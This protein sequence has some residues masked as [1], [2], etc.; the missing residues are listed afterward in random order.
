[1]K[2][3]YFLKL[4][5]FFLIL[6]TLNSCYYKPF[7]GYITNKKDFKHFS[8]NEKIAG[9]HSNIYRNYRV[10]K[11]DWNVEVFPEKKRIAGEM[12]IYFT[13]DSGQKTFLF[14]MQN[15]LKIK[16]SD[17]SIDK[18]KIKRN[19][20]LLYLY[21]D[22]KVQ[23]NTR[24]KLTIYYEGKPANLA[25]L[26]PIIW[27]KDKKDR[28]WIS[29]ATE[30]IGP[31]F[32]MPCNALLNAEADS[33]N[34]NVTV[35]KDLTAVANGQLNKVVNNDTSNTK[36]YYYKVT[37]PINNYNISFNVGHFKK[38]SKPYVDINGIKREIVCQVLDYNYDIADS[39]YNQT[40]KIMHEFEL[41]YGEFPWWNDGCKFVESN[42]AAM[43]HQSGI[44]LGT[45]YYNDWKQY[46]LTLVHELSHEW[47]GN[48]ITGKDYCDA[49]LHEGM[50]TYS[51][52]LF[53]EKV[54][55]KSD[56]D[57]IIH[58]YTYHVYNTIPIRKKCNVLYNSW[59]N[60]ADQD[61]YDKGALMMHSLRKVV[62]D[63]SLFF[64]SLFTIQ[65]DM[66]RQNVS[67]EEIILKFNELLKK[68]Y[69]EL[70]N[71][72]L[73]KAKPPILQIVINKEQTEIK[74]K[75]KEEIPFYK[76]GQITIKN[77]DEL[78]ELIPTTK[79]Q[80]CKID[81]IEYDDF[82]IEKSIYYSVDFL[83]K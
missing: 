69:S 8:K 68:D 27:K 24:I 30:G 70:F 62:N 21:F 35:P 41:M 12:T 1:M 19:H 61:I 74:Y 37:N 34:I 83:K 60:P 7:V 43:E 18:Y 25:G 17:C 11:Y 14:D 44:S 32:I 52:V 2:Q 39:F 38:I 36:T 64:N 47:W 67:T 63:D 71:W 46:N 49:W 57:N 56:Y 66:K 29:T 48:N 31:H 5:L 77:G 80:S 54:Y 78:L 53:V 23:A 51:E 40:P 15:R 33:V 73:N 22:E 13:T 6:F 3:K 79:Y 16:S 72:Y 81:S 4:A 26:G 42:Y 10:N 9:D 55:G 58:G 50:A 59:V 75:W 28:P 20:D 76:N 82:L 65:Q 45:I